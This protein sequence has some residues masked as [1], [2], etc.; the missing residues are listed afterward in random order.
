MGEIRRFR[1]R[2]EFR[3]REGSVLIHT[4][5]EGG[6]RI[7]AAAPDQRHHQTVWNR[8]AG[9]AVDD[10]AQNHAMILG[11]D[12][13]PAGGQDDREHRAREEPRQRPAA[14]CRCD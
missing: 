1:S 11:A 12:R 10:A 9:R 6:E 14:E 5:C 7:G 13:L 4:G 8:T 3:E 2:R